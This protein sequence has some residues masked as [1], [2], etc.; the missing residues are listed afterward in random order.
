MTA[1]HADPIRP[2]AVTA[3]GEVLIDL[4]APDA[5]DLEGAERFVRAAGGAPAN[6][7]VATAR[8]GVPAAFVGAVGDD[9][10]GRHARAV[11][12]RHGVDT[13]GVVIVPQGRGRTTL[14]LVAK[15]QGGI[16]E[17]IFYREAD[18]QL[19]PENIP[20]A[21]PGMSTWVHGSSMALLAEPAAS[22][23][24]QAVRLAHSAGALVSIDP[25]LRPSSWPSLDAARATILPLLG[26]ADVLKVNDLEARLFTGL[27]DLDAAASALA[28]TRSA[29]V[30]V[31]MGAAGCL[32]RR[33]DASGWVP[34]P[35][36]TVADTTGAGDAFVGA[37][38]AELHLRGVT[39]KRWPLVDRETID[40]S[41]RF[42]CAAA[43]ASCTRAGAMPSLPDRT[44]VEAL[45]AATETANTPTNGLT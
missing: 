14:A 13:R 12:E 8:L 45:L 5:P 43:S 15:N 39:A 31:T 7:A 36:V 44:T 24:H 23:T 42:A 18:A 22:A 11:L 4:I 1:G 6:V 41:L 25:N 21:L 37:L 16:P 2:I 33:G 40:L 28:P 27:D 10:F 20:P 34:A 3:V 38:L 32:W 9:P 19:T 17:F 30:V 26:Q 29:L 35:A